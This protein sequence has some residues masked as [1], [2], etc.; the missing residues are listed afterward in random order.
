MEVGSFDCISKV[1]H[2][3]SDMVG[4]SGL[5]SVHFLILQNGYHTPHLLHHCYLSCLRTFKA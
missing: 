3:P 5:C 2:R 4:S 1:I